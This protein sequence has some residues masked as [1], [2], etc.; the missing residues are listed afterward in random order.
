MLFNSIV[1]RNNSGKDQE[2]ERCKQK[3]T[4]QQEL[5]FDLQVQLRS[6]KTKLAESKE[7]H[8]RKIAKMLADSPETEINELTLKSSIKL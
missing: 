1:V 8:Q 4:S 5:I 6:S 2:L 3:I 7:K